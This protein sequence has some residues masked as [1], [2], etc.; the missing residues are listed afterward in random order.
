VTTGS[1]AEHLSGGGANQMKHRINASD[2][3]L[4]VSRLDGLFTP[5]T[6]Q[7]SL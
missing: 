1:L 4:V 6:M 3:L 5:S 7:D 2:S